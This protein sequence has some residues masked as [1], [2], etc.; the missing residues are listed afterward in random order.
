MSQF[1][2]ACKSRQPGGEIR[3]SWPS[4]AIPTC[5]IGCNRTGFVRCRTVNSPGGHFRH[6]PEIRL[7]IAR[8]HRRVCDLFKHHHY[9]D[10]NLHRAAKCFIGMIESRP[11]FFTAALHSVGK[12]SFWREHRTVCLLDFQGVGIGNM[13]ILEQYYP[14][15]TTGLMPENSY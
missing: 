11:I 15:R 14:V 7:E 13:I 6:W 1:E 2:C 5:S 10:T 12:K 8:V 3:S 9:S 4:P